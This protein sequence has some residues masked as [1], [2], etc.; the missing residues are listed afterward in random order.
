M[1][2]R[3]SLRSQL[4]GV[5]AAPALGSG[6]SS[7]RLKQGQKRVEGNA[8]SLYPAYGSCDPPNYCYK[9]RQLHISTWMSSKSFLHQ[10]AKGI[11]MSVAS[12]MRR[13]APFL[14]SIEMRRAEEA[15]EAIRLRGAS[16]TLSTFRL[17]SRQLYTI[18]RACLPPELLELVQIPVNLVSD[19]ST[20]IW[21]TA[22]LQHLVPC[23]KS[24]DSS[25]F[26]PLLI[27]LHKLVP[28]QILEI[29]CILVQS[30]CS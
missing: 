26:Q 25:G 13:P 23:T 20:V 21:L 30:Q 15:R 4:S 24:I 11:C 9:M 6:L 1:P 10:G 3:Q 28:L 16:I 27:Q 8:F 7:Q 29:V 18:L 2:S 12:E 22:H 19:V 17:Y 14:T 5:P